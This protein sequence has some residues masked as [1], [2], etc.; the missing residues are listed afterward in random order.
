MYVILAFTLFGGSWD[1]VGEGPALTSWVLT[2]VV[3]KPLASFVGESEITEESD[4]IDD[5][6]GG[7]GNVERKAARSERRAARGERRGFFGW[8]FGRKFG[9]G[10]SRRGGSC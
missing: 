2:D 10:G 5:V 9:G 7:C 6:G 3:N 1:L 4:A 8:L